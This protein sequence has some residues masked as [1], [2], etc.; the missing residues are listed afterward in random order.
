[1]FISDSHGQFVVLKWQSRLV[2]WKRQA[3]SVCCLEMTVMVSLF[4]G[5][6]RHDQFVLWK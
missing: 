6:D 2:V 4:F 3:W 5:N 1:M